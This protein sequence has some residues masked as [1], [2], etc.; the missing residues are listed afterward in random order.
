MSAVDPRFGY[1]NIFLGSVGDTPQVDG[2]MR[3]VSRWSPV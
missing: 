3:G 1:P 2:A